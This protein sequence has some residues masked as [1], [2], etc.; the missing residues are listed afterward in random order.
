MHIGKKS[1]LNFNLH[2][3]LYTKAQ[4]TNFL[5]A[6]LGRL[7]SLFGTS[8]V[9]KI[10]IAPAEKS[11][12]DNDQESEENQVPQK[13]QY[14]FFENDKSTRKQHTQKSQTVSSFPKGDHKAAR[15]RQDS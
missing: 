14:T 4:A 7:I 15:N 11:K 5:Y 10:P 6:G 1:C 2:L 12:Y 13:T 3:T 8:S 9:A